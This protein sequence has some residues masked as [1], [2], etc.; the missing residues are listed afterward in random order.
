METPSH[1][2]LVLTRGGVQYDRREGWRSRLRAV[3]CST[4]EVVWPI[5]VMKIRIKSTPPGE[6][7]EDIREAWIGLEIPVPS[8]FLGLRGGFGFG[9]LSGPTSWFGILFAIVTGRASRDV[10][11]IVEADLA[12]SLLS[13]K[14]PEA[15]A[16]WRQHA[17]RVVAPGRYLMFAAD[18]CEELDDSAA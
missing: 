4:A 17:P 16:W 11:Y 5:D 14:S 18:A 15:A 6:A 12:L 8:R 9:V 7:P 10:G 2:S 13:A 3:A 1:T